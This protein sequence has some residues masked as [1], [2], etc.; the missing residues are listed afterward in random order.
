MVLCTVQSGRHEIH[1][2]TQWLPAILDHKKNVMS[3]ISTCLLTLTAS[4][5]SFKIIFPK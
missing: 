4:I 3:N 5:R 1:N 2:D